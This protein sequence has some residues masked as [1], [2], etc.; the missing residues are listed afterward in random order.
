MVKAGAIQTKATAP[1]TTPSAAAAGRAI[2]ES[3]S[4]NA[5]QATVSGRRGRR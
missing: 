4:A 3:E 2:S 5:A 1:T